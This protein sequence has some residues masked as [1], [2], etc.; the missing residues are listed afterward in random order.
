MDTTGIWVLCSLFTQTKDGFKDL[1]SILLEVVT[2]EIGSR[3][4]EDPTVILILSNVEKI[5]NF[6]FRLHAIDGFMFCKKMLTFIVGTEYWNTD[7]E[8]F[9]FRI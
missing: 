2:N 8:N 9:L 1:W 5:T 4:V 6:K 3:L 7:A